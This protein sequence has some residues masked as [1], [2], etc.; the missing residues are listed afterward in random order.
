LILGLEENKKEGN[1]SKLEVVKD[2]QTEAMMLEVVG[3]N[4]DYLPRVGR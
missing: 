4:T 3:G 1:F 2:F